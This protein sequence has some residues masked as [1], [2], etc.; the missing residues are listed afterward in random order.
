M[1]IN[2]NT[3]FSS[4]TW[5]NVIVTKDI[6]NDIKTYVNGAQTNTINYNAN[7]SFT[8]QIRIGINRASDAYFKGNISISRL[9]VN[10]FLS[11]TEVLQNYNATKGRYL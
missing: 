5:Y 7:Y 8:E 2:L 6:N 10:K 1:S 4:N 11:D 9:Y 3:T